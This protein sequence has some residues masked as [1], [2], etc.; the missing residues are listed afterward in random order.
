MAELAEKVI[1]VTGAT[2]GIGLGTA[3]VLAREGARV[4]VTSIEGD[5][6]QEIAAA[7]PGGL[8][9][10]GGVRMD[11]S[12]DDERAQGISYALKRFGRIN[13]LV[14][15]AGVNFDKPFLETSLSDWRRLMSI[16]LESVF[17]LSRRVIAEFVR[18]GEG[19]AIVNIT[20]VHTLATYA[21]SAPYAAAKSAIN[22]FTKGLANE[23]ASQNIRVNCVA[24]GLVRTEIWNDTVASFGG[25]E[26]A[27]MDYWKKNIPL[28]RIIESEEIGESVSFLLSD[29]ARAIGGAVLYVDG[30]LTG[31]LIASR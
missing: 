19:G 28:G 10:H 24:P 17:D 22:M 9:R 21:G 29:R 5:R 31:Q 7:L 30:G 14:N 4:V 20:S 13:G 12:D 3:Q 26:A 11:V 18:Q 6:C 15:N 25:D 1:I 27:C 2:R 23:F 8:E 16:N